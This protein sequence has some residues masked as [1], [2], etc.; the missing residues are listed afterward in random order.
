M[1]PEGAGLTYV[2]TVYKNEKSAK[3][4]CDIRTYRKHSYYYFKVMV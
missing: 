1:S 3:K 2:A 4:V